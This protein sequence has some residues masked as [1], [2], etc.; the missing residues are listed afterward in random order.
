ML[1]TVREQQQQSLMQPQ[2][3]QALADVSA[4][5][6]KLAAAGHTTGHAQIVGLPG[7]P[8]GHS[9]QLPPLQHSHVMQHQQ[10]HH[11]MTS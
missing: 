4:D 11:L 5:L 1:Q 6:S 10:A 7:I 8:H 9:L 2:H 3:Q